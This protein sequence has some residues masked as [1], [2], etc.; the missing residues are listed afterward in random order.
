MSQPQICFLSF[1]QCTRSSL[2]PFFEHCNTHDLALDKFA[3]K[4]DITTR[5]PVQYNLLNFEYNTKFKKISILQ[6][7]CVKEEKKWMLPSSHCYEIT[8]NSSLLFGNHCCFFR[9]FIED[10]LS[11]LFVQNRAIL[12]N[13]NAYC[14]TFL[15]FQMCQIET[16][17][18][19]SSITCSQEVFKKARNTF[20]W[21]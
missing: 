19:T 10:S 20:W 12:A 4:V 21:L 14:R 9:L 17:L 2:V 11:Y 15:E 1:A 13:S 5:K 6:Y 7:V 18:S 8:G 3:S 16:W